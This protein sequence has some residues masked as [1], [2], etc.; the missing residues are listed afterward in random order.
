MQAG[1]Q[2]QSRVGLCAAQ[3]QAVLD[4]DDVPLLDGA[5]ES[6]A[7]G[8]LSSLHPQNVQVAAEVQD[9]KSASQHPLWPIL[10]DPQ[11]GERIPPVAGS[12]AAHNHLLRLVHAKA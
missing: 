9:A 8:I 10:F 2:Q 3:V 6:V 4:I 11:T 7:S 12:D 5:Q 1:A